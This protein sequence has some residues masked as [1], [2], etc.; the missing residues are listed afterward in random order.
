MS[1]AAQPT[2]PDLR[3]WRSTLAAGYRTARGVLARA[4]GWSRGTAVRADSFL[5]RR[6]V[7]VIYM[8]EIGLREHVEPVVSW[9]LRSGQCTVLVVVPERQR[10]SYRACTSL[11]FRAQRGLHLLSQAEFET[12]PGEPHVLLSLHPETPYPAAR[13]FAGSRACRIV[14]Q[15]GLSDKGAFYVEGNGIDDPLA[16]YDVVFLVGPIFREGSLRRYAEENPET[17][18]RLKLVAVG[19]PK[20]DALFRPRVPRVQVLNEL[21][22]DPARPVV[23]YAPTYERTASL[24]QAGLDIMRALASL[25][26]NVIVKLHHCSLKRPEDDPWIVHETA[27]KDWRKTVRALEREYANLRLATAHDAN[28]YLAASAVLVSDASGVAYEYLLLNRPLVFFDVPKLFES[29]G[30]NGIPYWGRR[31]GDIV[32]DTDE[33]VRSVRRGLENPM[34]KQREREEMIR[35]VVYTRG[36]ATERAGRAILELAEGPRFNP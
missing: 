17:Y 21:G 25:D 26:A 28:P 34:Y 29:Y 12:W 36:D 9:L 14:M 13:R 16:D 6:R 23:C 4:A 2:R 31:C 15:H 8:Q 32:R 35:R 5:H 22:L 33:L 3:R 27:G 11:P 7:I 19:A 24:E 1:V 18:K 30:T 20:T 10:G